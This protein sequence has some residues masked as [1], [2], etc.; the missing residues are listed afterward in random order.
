MRNAILRNHLNRLFLHAYVL[1]NLC[2]KSCIF[3]N[4]TWK[5]NKTNLVILTGQCS[6]KG[7]NNV[8]DGHQA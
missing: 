6:F 1:P 7:R 4:I 8:A 3:G 2:L 5:F